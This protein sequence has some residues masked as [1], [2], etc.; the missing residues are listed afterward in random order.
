MKSRT[1]AKLWVKSG[2][3]AFLFVF[4]LASCTSKS[5]PAKQATPRPTTPAAL[6]K[7]SPPPA[8]TSTAFEV[9]LSSHIQDGVYFH[10]SGVFSFQP[11]EGWLEETSEYGSVYFSEPGGEGAIYTTVTNTGVPLTFSQFQTFVEARELNFFDGFEAYKQISLEWDPDKKSAIAHKSVIF[12]DIPEEVF[13]YY[14][15]DLNVVYAT[16]TWMESDRVEEYQDVYQTLVKT[17]TVNSSSADQ[18]PFYNFVITFYDSLDAFSFEPPVSWTYESRVSAGNI[19]DIFSSPDQN[20]Y[21]IHVMFS[22]T[23]SLSQEEIEDKIYQAAFSEFPGNAGRA[24]VEEYTEYEDGSTRIF[25]KSDDSGWQKESI[26]FLNEG[27]LLVLNGVI[28]EGFEAYLQSTIDY[29]FDWYVVPA[30]GSQ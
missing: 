28:R 27:K 25:W 9:P 19:L 8:I 29:G 22:G 15:L 3:I 24:V 5:S 13:S 14:Q 4:S 6:R 1:N 23:N 10:P 2:L 26:Y 16:D 20:A 18:F 12:E 21:L 30:E 7:I 17:F 11:P